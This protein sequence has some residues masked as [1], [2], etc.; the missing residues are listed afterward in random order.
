[1]GIVTSKSRAVAQ[2]GLDRFS[3][4]RYFDVLVT[5]DDVP[6][7]KPD[8]HPLLHAA[9]MLGVEAENCAYV[10]DSPHD[11]TAAVAAGMVAVAA[12]WGVAGRERVLEPGPQYVV[13][14]MAECAALFDGH[15]AG[16]RYAEK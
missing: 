10:G 11:M 16:F 2:R 12:T 1:L 7:H 8:P 9:G 13:D 4:G 6:I 15:E 5:Y 3:L 14:S